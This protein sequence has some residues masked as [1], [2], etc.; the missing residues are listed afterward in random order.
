MKLGSNIL[1]KN[2][3]VTATVISFTIL[4]VLITIGMLTPL[5]VKFATGME[6]SMDAEYFNL[7]T[8][9][10]AILF[11]LLLSACLLAG[12][13]SQKQIAMFLGGTLLV[14]LAFLLFSPT[15][16]WKTDLILPMFI[17]SVLA[18]FYRIFTITK[19]R[20][21]KGLFKGVGAHVI[22]IGILLIIFGVIASST[23]KIEDSAVQVEDIENSFEN[24]D[25]SVKVTDMSSGYEGHPYKQYS[26]SSYVTHVSFEIYQNGAYFDSGTLDYITDLKWGQ[27]YTTTYIHRGIF[28]ELFIA[29]RALDEISHE[30]DLYVRVVPFISFVWAGMSLMLLGMI[31]LLIPELLQK[32]KA[33]QEGKI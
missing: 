33:I 15:G 18:A 4:V 27:T 10:F 3:L 16:D 17:A 19:E 29:P 22:H 11:T 8:A 1:S 24:M 23:M 2:N 31:I 13:Y 25:Y 7:R 30:I 6:L 26:G 32:E 20:S 5:I 9:P 21:G 12:R 14:S 28:E